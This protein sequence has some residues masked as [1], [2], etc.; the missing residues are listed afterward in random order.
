MTGRL[1]SNKTAYLAGLGVMF[2]VVSLARHAA[3]YGSD[4]MSP[5]TVVKAS[6]ADVAWIAG[7]WTK[8]DG[9]DRLEELWS[10]PRGDSMM[11]MF[12]WV[13][14]GKVW[15]YELMTIREE[16]VGEAGVPTLVFRFRHFSN[17]MNAWEPK[18][19]PIAYRLV[20]LGDNEAVFENPSSGTHR[21]YSIHRTDPGTLVVRVGAMRDGKLSSSEF[22]YHSSQIV[23]VGCATCIFHMKG[24]AGCKLAV[25][26]KGKAYLVTGSDID[27]HGDAHAKDGLCNARRKA[28]VTGKIDDGRFVATKMELQP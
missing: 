13:K 16:P 3:A 10:E 2:A 5:A 23:D 21:R 17:D 15:I 7:N 28:V 24:V 6:I 22:V 26:I 25:E 12:R 11:G 27:D 18:N 9:E 20:S 1:P 19:E 4:E 8:E 14:D